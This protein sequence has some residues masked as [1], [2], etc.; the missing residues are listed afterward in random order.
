MSNKFSGIEQGFKKSA[1]GTNNISQDLY[2]ENWE[3]LPFPN[4]LKLI[5]MRNNMVQGL[6]P[7]LE[8]LDRRMSEQYYRITDMPIDEL[9]LLYVAITRAKKTLYAANLSEFFILL[10]KLRT[11]LD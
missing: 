7:S 9:R 2:L 8:S 6:L 4:T 3:L 5:P 11:N 10:E 1:N